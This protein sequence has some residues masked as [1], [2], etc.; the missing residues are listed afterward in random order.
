MDS[1][2][3]V[4]VVVVKQS[5]SARL[6]HD[7]YATTDK[8]R[9]LMMAEVKLCHRVGDG[10][11]PVMVSSSVHEWFAHTLYYTPPGD[12]LSLSLSLSL[13]IYTTVI[14]QLV[15]KGQ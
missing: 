8:K 6:L 11:C 5:L 2:G 9:D 4:V 3:G 1:E 13:V 10:S 15:F 12:S 14:L 7:P